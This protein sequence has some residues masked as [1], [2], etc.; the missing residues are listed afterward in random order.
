MS[1][2]V[3][4]RSVDPI[5]VE[6]VRY[7]LVGVAEE[8]KSALARTAH[9]PIVHEVQDFSTGVFDAEGRLAAQAAGLAI[10]LGTL[11]WAVRAVID[12]YGKDD[13]QPGDVYLTNDPFEGGGT[14]LNDV[15][16]VEPIFAGGRL[17]G[18]AASRAHWNDIGGPVALSVQ[19]SAREVRAEGVLLPV[20][21]LYR[22]AT[23]NRELSDLLRAN[24][25][26]ANRQMGDL[27][28]QIVAGR[29]GAARLQELVERHGVGTVAASIV[30]FQDSSDELVRRRLRELPDFDDKREQY[31][32]D[33]GLGGAPTKIAVR[34]SKQ[35]D[36]LRLDFA[37]SDPA[38]PSGYNAARCAL[39]SGCR[40]IL[41]ALVDPESPA[42]DGSFRALTVAAPEGSVVS[43]VHPSAV[44]FYG[45]PT[46][47]AI[48]A[49]WQAVSAAVPGRLPA[50]H[51]GTIAGIAMV[52]WDD[53]RSPAQW[54]VYQGPNFGGWGA[55]PGTDGESAMCCVTN[56]DTRNT[57][58]EVIESQAPLR[59][60]RHELRTD[61]GGPGRWRGGLGAEYEF[62][63]LTGGPFAITC[64][65]GRT[66]FP[67]FG[68][69]GG[70]DGSLNVVE[71]RS[72][73]NR[74]TTLKR[75]TAFPLKLGDRVVV[76]TGGGGGY[77]H[78][79]ERSPAEIELDVRRGYVSP[80]A[81]MQ[82]HGLASR[83]A[84]QRTR[85]EDTPH[86]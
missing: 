12:K 75:A 28:A 84:R 66:D 71:V 47:R 37:G 33:D 83:R 11:D 48:D 67:P 26:D 86:G 41:K 85:A 8:M 31:L 62:E 80:A 56:G 73:A 49:I 13:L 46:R 78:A 3:I 42:N 30:R 25:R 9:T 2:A 20:L 50:G 17:C 6:V 68:A 23:L 14:H 29:V 27:N 64:A 74:I 51:F 35:G 54:A 70:S 1:G 55:S 60:H 77:G 72:G 21:R 39:V 43:A 57:P 32:D 38:T 53:R 81:A 44:S 59:V 15:S 69:E 22:G 24:V 19:T 16:V 76:T 63:V 5:T 61:S 18:F 52:G 40:V 4:E 34:V 82:T 36:E 79:L 45:E 7:A 65:L 58:A 10:F